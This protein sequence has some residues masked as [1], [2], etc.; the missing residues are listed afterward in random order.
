[1]LS[2]FLVWLRVKRGKTSRSGSHIHR[3]A[4]SPAISVRPEMAPLP[5][6]AMALKA[7]PAPPS[8]QVNALGPTPTDF[9]IEQFLERLKIPKTE[10]GRFKEL[11]SRSDISA[12]SPSS[13]RF[14]GDRPYRPSNESTSGARLAS[15]R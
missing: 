15:N 14:V 7:G 1:M 12:H 13:D 2:R 8:S 10:W 6:Q 3:P 5:M 11:L 4:I 9:E